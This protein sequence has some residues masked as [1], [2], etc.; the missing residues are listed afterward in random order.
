M[1]Q[2]RSN[3]GIALIELLI[4][5]AISSVIIGLAVQVMVL[6]RSSFL[7]SN[8][9]FNSKDILDT[10]VDIVR[11]IK[12]SNW[13]NISLEGVYHPEM[14]GDQWILAQGDEQIS[15]TQFS[16]S[17]EIINVCRDS[18]FLIVDCPDGTLDPDS[19]QLI[20][21][22]S[23]TSPISGS[24]STT[25]LLT[26][27]AG[28]GFW[29]QTTQ[30]DFSNGARRNIAL[31]A[32]S[33]GEQVL[34]SNSGPGWAATSRAANINITNSQSVNGIAIYEGRLFIVKDNDPGGQEFLIYN[35]S[36][37]ASPGLISA[38]ELGSN[39]KK[40]I[41]SGGYA[42]VA[43]SDDSQELKIYNITDPTAPLPIG[44]LDL[45]GSVDA[46]NLAIS[47]S[48]LYMI[49]AFDGTEK[50]F[51]TIN[52][53][54][55]AAPAL[56]S[57]QDFSDTISDIYIDGK[58]AYLSTNIDSQEVVIVDL[59]IELPANNIAAVFNISGTEN[60]SAV[61]YSYPNIYVSSQQNQIYVLSAASPSAISILTQFNL[62]N[63]G[64]MDI[65][66]NKGFFVDSASAQGL[67]IYDLTNP[68]SPSLIG[69]HAIGSN[70]TNVIVQG[71]YAFAVTQSNSRELI[72]VSGGGTNFVSTGT[73]YSQT[74]NTNNG[75]TSIQSIS[76]NS[77][78]PPS[79]SLGFQIAVNSLGYA[80]DY[81]GP[82][83]TS[84]TYY[85]SLGSYPLS[86]S[87]GQYIKVKVVLT[88][89]G[90]VS[91]TLDD[92]RITYIQ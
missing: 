29:N 20:F 11:S 17:V 47:G 45:P 70:A 22:V 16:R 71:A 79:T 89:D 25:Q 18:N 7:S 8:I 88:G 2:S 44:S 68:A 37:P 27:Y 23:W 12:E 78:N 21:N 91:P 75:L 42:Y 26:R 50:E 87:R 51:N 83:G 9:R 63:I 32:V 81:L 14:S 60:T 77:T 52:I 58:Y 33:D 53:T 15:G 43:T 66:D 86:G 6:V 19:K 73:F 76:W 65:M 90:S 36:N 28:N 80:F 30:S 4:A 69:N 46:T 34:E 59:S 72:V 64:D 74:L 35:I 40:I 3:K 13:D 24:V 54:N 55:A 62:N 41:V 48:R 92:F 10:T 49:R 57:S 39:G 61:Y 85:T 31:T 67:Y 82:D 5:I 38:T 84:A 56:I 1:A